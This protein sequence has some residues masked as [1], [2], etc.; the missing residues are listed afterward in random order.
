MLKYVESW[1]SSGTI[2]Q[3]PWGRFSFP[4]RNYVDRL[5]WLCV[6]LHPIPTAIHSPAHWNVENCGETVWD[7]L[8]Y[9]GL[10][11]RCSQPHSAIA[12]PSPRTWRWSWWPSP[13]EFQITD[14]SVRLWSSGE[15]RF[16]GKHSSSRRSKW[17]LL[18]LPSATERQRF[19]P[20]RLDANF[21]EV[22]WIGHLCCHVEE[23]VLVVIHLKRSIGKTS[24][25]GKSL[26]GGLCQ[27]RNS[28]WIIL[29]GT[30]WWA[31]RKSL[32]HRD[33]QSLQKRLLHIYSAR[34]TLHCLFKW[35]SIGPWCTFSVF[36]CFFP[37]VGRKHEITSHLR[38]FAITMPHCLPA[39]SAI[40]CCL[41]TL[42]EPARKST[43]MVA[44]CDTW[45]NGMAWMGD[46]HPSQGI[47]SQNGLMTKSPRDWGYTPTFDGQHAV[48]GSNPPKSHWSFLVK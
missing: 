15:A 36:V 21:W 43:T 28:H 3:F 34:T 42:P 45:S 44:M 39:W 4:T 22:V 37:D 2:I 47:C 10:T 11:Q 26:L 31:P 1:K 13:V 17:S 7:G 23:E 12:L 6:D 29:Q 5:Q 35:C 27:K 16:Q 41:H 8:E 25:T 18:L 24:I 20:F 9:F 33:S 48:I 38:R 14:M 30:K 19:L 40:D 32:N 46:D